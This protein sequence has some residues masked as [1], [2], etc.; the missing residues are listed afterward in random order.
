[1]L[2]IRQQR[3]PPLKVAPGA[4]TNT[5]PR[6]NLSQTR[7]FVAFPVPTAR[8]VS[9]NR[10]VSPTC[11]TCLFETFRS[12]S[13]GLFVFTILQTRVAPAVAGALTLIGAE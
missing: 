4:R 10:T 2:A 1:M 6:G 3:L 7:T 13:F 12:T 11:T 9:V 5:S 8:S